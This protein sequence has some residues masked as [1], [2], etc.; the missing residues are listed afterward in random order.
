MFVPLFPNEHPLRLGDH[1]CET[2]E[3]VREVICF[4]ERGKFIF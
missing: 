1:D 4:D 2:I 3:D